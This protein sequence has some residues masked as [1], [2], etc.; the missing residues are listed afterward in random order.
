MAKKQ[1]ISYSP[2]TALIQG[3]G[4]AYRNYDNA[5]GMYAG[6][7]KI[8]EAGTEMVEGAIKGF[9]AEE[10]SLDSQSFLKLLNNLSCN[11]PSY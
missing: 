1:G 7:D 5:P 4:I 11:T 9:E 2:N 3:A 8:T 6:L 10:I